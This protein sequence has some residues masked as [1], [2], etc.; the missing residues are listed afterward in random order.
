MAVQSITVVS[1]PVSDQ[2]RAKEFY[3]DKLGMRLV[4]DDDSI[5]GLRWIQVAPDSGGPG[6]TLVDWFEQMPPGSVQ[7]LVLNSDDLDTDYKAMSARGVS[8]DGP[9]TQQLW[10]T[11]AVLHDPDGNMLVLQQA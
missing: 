1:V 11:E 10:A 8:F 5:P 4:R 9:P 7:G 6:L 3:L 2:E